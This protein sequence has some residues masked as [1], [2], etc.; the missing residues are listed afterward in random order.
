MYIYIYIYMA[1]APSVI[2]IFVK[3]AIFPQF[4]SKNG[5]KK[6]AVNPLHLFQGVPLLNSVYGWQMSKLQNKLRKIGIS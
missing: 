5:Q 6:G 2:H 3:N 1:T 4:Y